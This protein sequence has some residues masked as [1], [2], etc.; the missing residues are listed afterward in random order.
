M[1]S[2]ASLPQALILLGLLVF[3]TTI[4]SGGRQNSEMSMSTPSQSHRPEATPML[5][6]MNER[7]L[8]EKAL[9]VTHGLPATLMAMGSSIGLTSMQFSR[10]GGA[11]R[12][13]MT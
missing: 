10:A 4:E 3:R 2:E 5:A 1:R 8:M 7:V 11:R 13:G 9:P 6:A 12:L